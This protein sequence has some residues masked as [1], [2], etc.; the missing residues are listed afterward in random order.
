MGTA[1]KK[2]NA[3]VLSRQLNK[4][5]MSKTVIFDLGGVYFSNGTQIAIGS[6]ASKYKIKREPVANILNGDAGG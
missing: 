1:S 3:I 2:S 5:I 6:I 4:I